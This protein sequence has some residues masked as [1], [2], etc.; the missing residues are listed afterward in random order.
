MQSLQQLPCPPD[1]GILSCCSCNAQYGMRAV[2]PCV[3][4][5]QCALYDM[6]TVCLPAVLMGKLMLA[7]CTFQSVSSC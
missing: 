1:N 6:R 2:H 5:R 3:V 4:T 7:C